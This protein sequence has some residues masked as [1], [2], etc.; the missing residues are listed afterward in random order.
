MSTPE[1]VTI[2]FETLAIEPRPYYPPRPVG[3]AIKEPGRR[4]EYLAW[5]HPSP[6]SR[7]ESGNNTTK[8]KA[9]ARL[10][11]FWRSRR[12]LLFHNAKFDLEVARVWLDL[13]YP[14]W[15]RIHDTLLLAFL[16][17]P[18][19]EVLSLKPLAERH[20]G[21]PPSEEFDL[22]AWIVQNVPKAR[23]AKTRW[24]AYIADAPVRLVGPYAKG[25][26]ARTWGLFKK[27]W[28]VIAWSDDLKRAYDRERRLMFTL[29]RMED[30]GLPIDV[31]GLE[32]AIVTAQEDLDRI[33]SW[34]R[35][36]VGAPGIDLNKKGDLADALESCGAVKEWILTPKGARSVAIENLQEVV[37]DK[38]LL[39]ALRYRAL[40]ANQLRTF[41]RPWLA[42]AQAND[43]LV[44]PSWNQVRQ[45][46]ERQRG[47][48]IGAR[49]GR[50][51][52][53]PNVQN[54]PKKPRPLVTTA[55]EFATLRWRGEDPLLVPIG[56]LSFIDLR[57]LIRAPR[58]QRFF[59]LDYNQHELRILAHYAGGAM[60]QAYLDNPK[61]DHHAHARKLINLELGTSF[62]RKPVKNTGFGIIYGM[63]L[64]A[65][66][67]KIEED[68][69]TAKLIRTAYRGIFPGLPEF[70][71]E[72]Q[73]RGRDGEEV[74]TWGGRKFVVEEPRYVD[75]R[76]R[77]FEYKII[78]T[79]IQ[80]SAADCVKEAMVTYDEDPDRAGDLVLSVHDELLGVA[81]ARLAKSELVRLRDH[82]MRPKFRLPMVADGKTGKTW[83]ACASPS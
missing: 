19:A 25:D 74:T 33:D 16:V 4:P 24:G 79:I 47:R 20:L 22:Q 7:S 45:A 18:N 52:S 83:R 8:A 27:F 9:Q 13:P 59:N 60:L 21:V 66:A 80:G 1:C 32:A 76:W 6:T 58:G 75:G 72:C 34:T 29:L 41:A 57:A 54:I 35:R 81:D 36:R 53:S 48:A 15:Q 3:V 12:P 28:K 17:D 39:T 64:P 10:S 56:G 68:V 63:G 69:E 40:L 65:L 67:D 37:V 50:L 82:M 5:E 51:S 71:K 14:S 43:G 46:D 62:A 42:M 77:T 2:D 38:K 30:R 26:V 31:P 55:R 11:R 61:L 44:C 78:N 23:R 70:E 49:T 73:R